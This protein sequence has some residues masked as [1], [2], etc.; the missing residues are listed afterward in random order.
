MSA[1][2]ITVIVYHRTFFKKEGTDGF[3][4]VTTTFTLTAERDGG[5][6]TFYADVITCNLQIAER[7]TVDGRH[8]V[9]WQVIRGQPDLLT[10]VVS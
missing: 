6:Y 4:Q 5:A 3:T 7:I 10:L 8:V 2:S 1:Q 9:S